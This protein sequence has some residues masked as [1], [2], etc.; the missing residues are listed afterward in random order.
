MPQRIWRL[1]SYL[2]LAWI[3]KTSVE[4]MD[5]LQ[6]ASCIS[7]P[8][9][10]KILLKWPKNPLELWTVK[11]CLALFSS[12]V[13]RFLCKV[14]NRRI[15]KGK[16]WTAEQTWGRIKK[17][18]L[19]I[20]KA[21]CTSELKEKSTGLLQNFLPIKGQNSGT[22][23]I[24]QQ[25]W[26]NP[27]ERTIKFNFDGASKGNPVF[28]GTG[29]VFS[30]H[31][32]NIIQVHSFLGNTTNNQAEVEALIMDITY[33]LIW[34][35]QYIIVEGDSKVAVDSLNEMNLNMSWEM[36]SPV[37][38]IQQATRGFKS[39]TCIHLRKATNHIADISP[40]VTNPCHRHTSLRGIKET[41]KGDYWL[42]ILKLKKN[43]RGFS[44]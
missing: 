28:A 29:G 27:S 34:H 32:G 24:Y 19:E 8:Y 39:C 3:W 21:K 35:F 14:R 15:F 37:P 16:N 13:S 36:I 30:G 5:Q 12:F 20:A 4:F 2:P 33:P 42:I 26:S 40:N 38:W 23:V 43:G 10:R 41:G 7:F 44:Y 18:I 9:C 6:W 1:Q 31:Q 11:A 25:T 22:Y 17:A